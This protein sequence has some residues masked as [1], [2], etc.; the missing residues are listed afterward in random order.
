MESGFT[1]PD[2][3]PSAPKKARTDDTTAS[4]PFVPTVHQKYS[5]DH[6]SASINRSH[7]NKRKIAADE[8]PNSDG[9]N[10]AANSGYID[11]SQSGN[12]YSLHSQSHLGSYK[13]L[14]TDDSIYSRSM[15][16]AYYINKST[17]SKASSDAYEPTEK[18]GLIKKLLA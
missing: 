9:N 7:G 12:V 10:I 8:N 16:G 18:N 5:S 6:Y 11:L 3:G 1:V 15:V 4:I 17:S 13:G 2:C 14:E